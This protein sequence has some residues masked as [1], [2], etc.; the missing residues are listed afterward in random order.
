MFGKKCCLI[1][2]NS[3]F[4]RAFENA[5]KN[6]QGQDPLENWYNFISWIEQTY[7]KNGHEGNLVQVLEQCLG[8]F[9]ND[10]RYIHDRRFCRLWIKYVRIN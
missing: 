10:K 1:I 8:L 4:Y 3:C 5:I 7:P 9:E 6:Y 2:L